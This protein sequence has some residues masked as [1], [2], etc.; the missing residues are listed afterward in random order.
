MCRGSRSVTW[1]STSGIA[2]SDQGEWGSIVGIPACEPAMCEQFEAPV[3]AL[4]HDQGFADFAAVLQ[5]EL[6]LWSRHL[7]LLY[8]LTKATLARRCAC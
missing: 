5:K 3:I 4:D 6:I 7:I 2:A 1:T 8:D